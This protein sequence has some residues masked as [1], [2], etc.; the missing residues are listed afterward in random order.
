MIQS[1]LE[2]FLSLSRWIL[3]CKITI[4][5]LVVNT[6]TESM[7][8]EYYRLEQLTG[9]YWYKLLENGVLAIGNHLVKLN[10]NLCVSFSD[11]YFCRRKVF[12]SLANFL[13]LKQEGPVQ[14]W[15]IDSTVTF[16]GQWDNCFES[17]YS[18]KIEYLMIRPHYFELLKVEMASPE[19]RSS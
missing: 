2:T 9:I 1:E 7:W 12:P 8:E 15:L 3:M 4:K 5:I 16:K 13:S 17:W 6:I 11:G 19:N 10:R 14:Y 18:L